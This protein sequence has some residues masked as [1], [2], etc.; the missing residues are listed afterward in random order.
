M[1]EGGSVMLLTKF[2]PFTTSICTPILGLESSNWYVQL[3]D[4]VV[5]VLELTSSVDTGS[6]AEAIENNHDTMQLIPCMPVSSTKL[7]YDIILLFLC[8]FFN[9]HVQL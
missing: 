9:E 4:T 8:L 6:G 1:A 2:S 5:I 7:M 3:R